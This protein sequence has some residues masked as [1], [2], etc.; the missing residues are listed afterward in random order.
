M[1][2]FYSKI[3]TK[4]TPSHINKIESP[5]EFMGKNPHY[6]NSANSSSKSEFTLFISVI[7]VHILT[8][9]FQVRKLL[10]IFP[11]STKN[12]LPKVHADNLVYSWSQGLF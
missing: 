11:G 10:E 5:H 3:N 2:R 9:A 12:C 8:T 1:N 6:V 7:T 4:I